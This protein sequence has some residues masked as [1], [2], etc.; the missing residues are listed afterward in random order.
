MQLIDPYKGW[1]MLLIGLGL[2]WLISF[3]WTRSLANRLSLVREMRFGW[4]QVGDQLEERFSLINAGWFPALWV[5]VIDRSD[6]PGYK[7]SRATGVE[8][9]SSNTWHT[10]GLCNRRG[11]FRLGPTDLRTGDPFGIYT[12][13]LHDSATTTL[14]VMPPIIPLPL[15]DVATGGRTGEAHP[16]SDAPERT[17]SAGSVR[18]WTPGDSLRWIHWRT[19]ARRDQPYVRVFDGTP[20]GDWWILLDMDQRVQA[21]QD[22]DSTTEHS[23]ILAA[24]L[25]DRG[26]RMKRAVGLISNGKELVWLNPEEGND[27]RWKIL[28]A[29]AL[30]DLGEYTLSE[31]LER[32]APSIGRYASLVIITPNTQPDWIKPLLRLTWRG[33]VPTV[34]LLDPAMFE[35]PIAESAPP[36]VEP[37]VSRPPATVVMAMLTEIGVS[38]YLIGRDL[39]DRPEAR[40]GLGG[41]WEW[42]VMP[43]G[44]AIPVRRPT[45]ITWKTLS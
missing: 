1:M 2:T 16:R 36:V 10:S 43:T 13:S 33:V 18:E 40:P 6:M 7:V 22:W 11:L 25:A 41:R 32:V 8:G 5:E 4:A 17:V 9:N 35:E 19:F 44:R 23:I 39:I 45:D 24:S 21:G 30:A 15:I 31:L 42:R 27:H 29:L 34:L 37:A 14:M 26:L 28:R 38:R 12:A 20:A 3:L